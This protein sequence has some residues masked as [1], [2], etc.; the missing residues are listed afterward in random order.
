MGSAHYTVTAYPKDSDFPASETELTDADPA[1]LAGLF[2]IPV[3]RFVDVYP[4]DA[5]HMAVL[6]RT[7]GLAFDPAAYDYFLEVTA[8]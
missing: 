6:E 4:M 7:A 8:G 2:G 5:E 3:E 1:F